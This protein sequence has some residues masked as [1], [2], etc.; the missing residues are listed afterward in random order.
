MY[1]HWGKRIFDVIVASF[2]LLILMPIMLILGL[3]IRIFLGSPI[4]FIQQRPGLN[5]IPFFLYKFRT[6]LVQRDTQGNMLHDSK[7]L[8]LLGKLLRSLSLDELPE[9]LNVIKGDMSLVGPRPLLMEYLGHYST[10]Q[11]KR[12]DVKPGLTGWAQINGRNQLSWEEK[13]KLDVWYVNHCSLW[14]DLKIILITGF[15]IIKREGI[16]AEGEATMSRFDADPKQ[17][18]MNK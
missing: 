6:M 2:M 1:N 12:H 17:N 14:L 4:F 15:K 18:T 11:R 3:L 16:N 8:T 7:R 9:L 13:F 5:E 10:E